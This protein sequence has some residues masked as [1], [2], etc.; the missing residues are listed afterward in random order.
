MLVIVGSS[1]LWPTATVLATVISKIAGMEPGQSIGIRIPR[2]AEEPT[3]PLER[4]V[5]QAGPKMGHPVVWWRADTNKR[6]SVYRRDYEMVEKATG[7]LA[8]FAPDREMEGGT[9]HVVTA[10]LARNVPVEAYRLTDDGRPEL[11]G[12]DG[13]I[14][15]GEDIFV[16]P[17]AQINWPTI[18]GNGT[19]TPTFT[20]LPITTTTTTAGT[21]QP[22]GAVTISRDFYDATAFGDT[23]KTFFSGLSIGYPKRKSKP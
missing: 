4:W 6:D 14:P 18:Y 21:A 20:F 8:F 11:L 16:N 23:N 13:L 5:F 17:A 22:S 1:D 10:A 12:S 19:A 15:Q 7:V 2:S 9:G 3:S